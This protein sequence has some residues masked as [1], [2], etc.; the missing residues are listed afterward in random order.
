MSYIKKD[1]L[2]IETERLLLRLLEPEEAPL[3]V[4]YVTGNREHLGPWEPL[5]GEGYF[6][7]ETWTQELRNRQNQF[8]TGSGVRLVIFFKDLPK[9]P[10][11]G[12]C[13]FTDIMRGVFQSCHL[14]YSTHYRYQG[15]GIM[16][17]ALAAACDFMLN[18]LKLHRVQAN[19]IPRN[20][21]S[22]RLLRK[23]GFVVEGYA[24]DYLKINGK[25]EDHILTSKIRKENV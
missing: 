4:Q 14:G 18:V 24:R 15:Q 7:E 21:R 20:E 12:V 22:G 10:I 25:W 5:R 2:P 9:G 16:Y 6:Q 13:N 19:Y 17:E 23:L 1:L 11:I 8:F 3:M